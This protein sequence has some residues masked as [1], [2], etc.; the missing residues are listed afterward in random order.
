MIAN[1]KSRI[2]RPGP[3]REQPVRRVERLDAVGEAFEHGQA[4]RPGDLGD[5]RRARLEIAIERERVVRS[6]TGRRG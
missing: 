6:V 4:Q 3:D 1:E 5:G 2:E